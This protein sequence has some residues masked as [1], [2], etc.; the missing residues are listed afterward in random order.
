MPRLAFVEEQGRLL[1]GDARRQVVGVEIEGAGPRAVGRSLL[2]AAAR[3][4]LLAERRIGPDHERRLGHQSRNIAAPWRRPCVLIAVEVLRR[5]A[6]G[7][8]AGT[9]GWCA[10]S[11]RIACSVPLKP[12]SCRT[13]S[14]SLVIRATSLEAELVDLL[15]GQRQRRRRLDQVAVKLVAALHVHQADA[16]ARV[17]RYSFSRKSRSRVS[18]G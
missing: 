7:S 6:R 2:V 13:F 11:R 5:A 17:A 3:L 15:R 12:T 8:S 14:N 9:W 1:P 10:C 4:E 16:V 18:A